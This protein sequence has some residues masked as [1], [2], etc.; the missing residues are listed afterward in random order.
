MTTRPETPARDIRRAALQ[1]G[2]AAVGFSSPAPRPQAAEHY[3]QMLEE[4]RNAEM[5]YLERGLAG[6]LEPD[7]LLPGVKTIVSL[8]ISYH[9]PSRPKST[10]SRIA[11]YARIADYHRVVRERAE[12]LLEKIEQILGRRPESYI[13]IDSA[14][15]LEKEHAEQG[16]IGRTGKNTLLIVPSA[17]SHVFLA[18]LL[19]DESISEER[20][21]LPNP[22]GSC[23]I[24]ID[25]CPTGALIAPG[26]L[27]ATRCISYLTVELK[28]EFTVEES[29]MIGSMLFGCDACGEHCPHNQRPLITAD[30]AFTP[31][32]ELLELPPE[33]IL[34]LTRSEFKRLFGGT[35]IWRIGLKRL[36]RNAS[37]VLANLEREVPEPLHPN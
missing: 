3:R 19:I 18:E 16:G 34:K 11:R 37:A 9:T 13:A 25:A 12:A 26:K 27:D 10:A 28:R 6:R 31:K 17:G 4:G 14:P 15:L 1:L 5:A 29:V 23:S 7:L 24:C 2:F 35:P 22:C 32:T 30:P 20:P 33:E 36:K 8:A 21:P